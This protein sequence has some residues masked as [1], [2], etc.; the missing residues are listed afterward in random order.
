[1]MA[2]LDTGWHAHPRI[3]QL[4]LQAMGL[5]A[6][7]ISYCDHARS[8][9]FIPLG[10]WPALPGAGAAVKALVDA[11]LWARVEGGFMLHDYLDYNRSRAKIEA[12][13]AAK[14]ANGQAG[15]QASASARARAKGQAPAQAPA[16]AST[17]ANSER[18]LKR[19][20]TP[21]P[22]PGPGVNSVAAAVA[23]SPEGGVGETS[24]GFRPLGALLGKRSTTAAA[25]RENLSDE[26][27]AAIADRLGK[28]PLANAC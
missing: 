7:S 3:L 13:L 23:A 1:M 11:E 21:G 9:G 8:D 26:A 24:A 22:G 16:Q 25:A 27:R 4:G 6:W 17:Q 2:R 15:G 19:N 5:H 14:R 10:A 18:A 20:S 28:P 12:E